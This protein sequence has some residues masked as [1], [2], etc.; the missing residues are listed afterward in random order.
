MHHLVCKTSVQMK[1]YVGKAK[2][3]SASVAIILSLSLSRMGIVAILCPTG[4]W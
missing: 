2:S 3:L 4:G 1:P